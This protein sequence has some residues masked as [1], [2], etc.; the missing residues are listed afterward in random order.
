[1]DIDRKPTTEDIRH[2]ASAYWQDGPIPRQHPARIH[3]EE[4]FD[5]WLGEH[6][7]EV[8]AP[9]LALLRDMVD[10]DPCWLDHHG[11]CQAHGYL[12]LQPGELCPHAE[13]KQLLE[14]ST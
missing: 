10:D 9:F 12:S 1:M 7:A 5:Q 6:E 3:A 13:A 4:R 2:D 11:G 14:E 8:K